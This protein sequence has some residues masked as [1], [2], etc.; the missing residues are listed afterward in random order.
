MNLFDGFKWLFDHLVY[1]PQLNLLKF[2]LN[3]TSDIGLSIILVAVVVNL[4]LW[5][6]IADSYLS[7]IKMRILQPKIKEIQQKYKTVPGE[8]PAVLMQKAQ[9]MRQEQSTL[10]KEHGVK[11]GTFFWVLFLQLFFASGVFYVVNNVSN[12]VQNGTPIT[13]LYEWLFQT[14]SS[15]FPD[16]AFGFMKIFLPSTNY[17]WLP[18][19][20]LVLSYLY[21][22]YVFHWA[23]NTKVIA[24]FASS[25]NK[26]KPS[27]TKTTENE[28]PAIDPEALQRNQEFVIIYVMP[29]FTFLIN[30]SFSSGLNLYFATLSLVNLFRQVVITQYYANNVSK[31]VQDLTQSDPADNDNDPSND[32]KYLIQNSEETGKN[33]DLRDDMVVEPK[34]FKNQSKKTPK[35]PIK[36][37]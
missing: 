26:T 9:Q 23:P 8:T 12:S 37:K 28:L 2:F 17:I 13:G 22:K 31:L 1:Y 20:S 6:V 21:G 7:G 25:K 27:D 29:V 14:T 15:T 4:L 3:L 32:V 18:V 30:S 33:Q 19:A 10:F 16:T 11:T 24:K 35:K 36:N 34:K 5:R